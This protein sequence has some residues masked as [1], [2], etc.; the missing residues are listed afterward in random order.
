MPKIIPS[1][2]SRT[3]RKKMKT[4]L[5]EKI[6]KFKFGKD[7]SNFLDDL[8]TESEFV[9]LTRRLKIAKMLIEG[10]TYFEIKKKLKTSHQTIRFVREK[11]NLGDGGFYKF[12]KQIKI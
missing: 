2:L 6:A 5:C 10:A 1:K 3:E 8:L 7:V 12:V 9:M 11:I 4:L